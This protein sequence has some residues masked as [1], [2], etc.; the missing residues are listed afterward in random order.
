MK[1]DSPN[2]DPLRSMPQ[3]IDETARQLLAGD[4]GLLAIDESTSTCNR[5]LAAAGIT[6]DAQ[7]RWAYRDMLITTPGLGDSISGAILY[8]ESIRASTADGRRFVDV[9][10]A[11]GIIPGIKV[12]TGT[13]DL[14][15]HPGERVTEGLDGLRGRLQEYRALG[16]RFAKWRAVLAIQ[17]PG[18]APAGARRPQRLPSRACMAA[19]AQALARYAALCQEAGLV[20]IVE[21]EVLMDGDH[22]LAECGAVTEEVLH[23]VFDHMHVQGVALEAM[24]LKTNMVLPGTDCSTP[25]SPAQVATATIEGLRRAVPVAVPGIVFLSGGQSGT[26]A[27]ARLNA[28]HAGERG[29]ASPLPWTLSFSYG[30]ALQEPALGIWHGDGSRRGAAQAAL[31]HRARCNRAACGGT[32]D[33][34]MEAA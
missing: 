4:K 17:A 24:L 28:M 19:N 7:T 13:T 9:L 26:L 10:T 33:A 31:L 1:T 12:D 23:A 2:P 32:Y 11:A 34:A 5:R 6:A 30:R 21:P 16:A 3:R 25:A 14:A 8:D 20:P 22:G 15:G 27:S 29:A 18:G